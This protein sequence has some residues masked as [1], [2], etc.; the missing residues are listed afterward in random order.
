METW[1]AA[2]QSQITYTRF[3][4]GDFPPGIESYDWLVVMGGPMGVYDDATL[5]WLAS[6]K[7]AIVA[8]VEAK[9]IVLGF[10]LGAQ[11]LALVMGGKVTRNPNKEIGWHLI[12]K[13]EAADSIW[14]GRILPKLLLTFHWHGDTFALPPEAI[15]LATSEGCMQQGFVIG[16]RVVGLQFH[17]EATPSSIQALLGACAEDLTEGPFV[18]PK[19]ALAGKRED[20]LANGQFLEKLLS[21]LEACAGD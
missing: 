6:E 3:Y 10:C 4:A 21:G 1:F 17:P 18:Q 13:T 2:H 7:A 16:N 8:A 11:L 9:K 14:I 12:Q 5:P 20:F 19:Q 15:P